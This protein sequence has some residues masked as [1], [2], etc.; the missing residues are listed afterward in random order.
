MCNLKSPFP[1][2]PFCIVQKPIPFHHLFSSFDSNSVLFPSCLISFRNLR[3]TSRHMTHFPAAA[4]PPP[5]LSLPLLLPRSQQVSCDPIPITAP[6]QTHFTASLH[7]HNQPYLTSFSPLNQPFPLPPLAFCLT[8]TSQHR[9]AF[10][11]N[12]T[13]SFPVPNPVFHIQL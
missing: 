7:P 5:H 10:H 3:H 11:R 1:P 8:K 12:P 13:S 4:S 6:Q 9:Y 2:S